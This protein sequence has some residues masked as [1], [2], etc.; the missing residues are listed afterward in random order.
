M[1]IKEF[2]TNSKTV[3]T[4]ENFQNLL[5]NQYQETIT[6]GSSVNL[7]SCYIQ[8]IDKNKEI[9]TF[10]FTDSDKFLEVL[11]TQI[12]KQIA[13]EKGELLTDSSA[14]YF[15]VIGKDEKYY[16][17][18][19]RWEQA[20]KLWRCGAYLQEDLKLPEIKIFFPS[21]SL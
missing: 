21:L 6:T 4:S 12:K 17:V 9:G 7:S 15:F 2:F 18:L 19:V 14:N 16:S 20:Q 10:V 5:L 11:A 3:W 13:G 8:E 1:N